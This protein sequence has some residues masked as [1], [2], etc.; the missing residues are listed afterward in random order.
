MTTLQTATR[1]SL[2]GLVRNHLDEKGNL[3]RRIIKDYGV[4]S[5]QSPLESYVHGLKHGH[6]KLVKK[7]DLVELIELLSIEAAEGQLTA[8]KAK[9]EA[10]KRIPLLG[11]FAFFLVQF[12]SEHGDRAVMALN[13]IEWK[14]RK[15][16]QAGLDQLKTDLS[17]NLTKYDEDTA[18]LLSETLQAA[19]VQTTDQLE[20]WL[21]QRLPDYVQV[22][23][24]RC[25]D[26]SSY[27]AVSDAHHNVMK[28]AA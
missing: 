14:G 24:D 1:N 17:A 6:K 4:D 3:R 12:G 5:P 28:V 2:L 18:S 11:R 8:I 16:S 19:G 26:W 23:G 10:K 20:G 9:P 13:A 7:D 22:L 21:L 25:F 27:K 15:L